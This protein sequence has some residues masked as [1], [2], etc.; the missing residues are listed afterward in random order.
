[1]TQQAEQAKLVNQENQV[2]QAKLANQEKQAEQA[3]QAEQTMGQ[4]ALERL[5]AAEAAL[6]RLQVEEPRDA[7]FDRESQ[8]SSEWSKPRSSIDVQTEGNE[9]PR[10][11]T[12]GG[13]TAAWR[14]P[15]DPDGI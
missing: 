3:E 11:E 1:M 9:E 12:S 14:D 10:P 8:S 2:E 13:G 15:N 6:D 5:Q 7:S 4:A